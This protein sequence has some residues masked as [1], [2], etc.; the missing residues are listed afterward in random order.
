MFQIQS[1]PAKSRETE[2]E[3]EQKQKTNIEK[4]YTTVRDQNY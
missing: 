4:L 1:I 2:R 3:S